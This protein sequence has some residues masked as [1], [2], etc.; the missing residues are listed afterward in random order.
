MWSRRKCVLQYSWLWL[1]YTGYTQ[2]VWRHS[3]PNLLNLQSMVF[4]YMMSINV[5]LLL[6]FS[7][8]WYPVFSRLFFPLSSLVSSPSP[9][10]SLLFSP[11]ISPLLSCL[12]FF[13]FL[14]IYNVIWNTIS[15]CN[16]ITLAN[17]IF[18]TRFSLPFIRETGRTGKVRQSG[19]IVHKS[20]QPCCGCPQKMPRQSSDCELG[21]F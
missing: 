13:L 15:D 16:L 11:A 20:V 6:F 21:I 1:G 2:E 8:F 17:I 3:I 4:S 10:P 12:V 9:I 14:S 18:K 19:G 7:F 5:V